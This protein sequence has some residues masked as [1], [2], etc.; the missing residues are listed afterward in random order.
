MA[1]D[2]DAVRAVAAQVAAALQAA[3][4]TVLGG[5]LDPEVRWGPPGDPEPPCQ[6]RDQVL[7]W[8][9]RGRDAGTR[10]TVTETVVSGDRILVGMRVTG[11]PAGNGPHDRWQVLT[12]RGGR[13]AEIAGF[14]DRIHA[15]EWAG[16]AGAGARAGGSAAGGSAEGGSAE[17]AARWVPPREPL[18]DD[19]VVVRLPAPSDADV[20]HA[21]AAQPGGLDGTWL[22][23]GEGAT[24]ASCEWLISD[25]LAGW[26]SAY[27]FHGPAL[28]ITAAGCG[29]LVGQVGLRARGE[30]A[31]EL[32]YGVAPAHRGRGYAARAVRLVAG[33]LL[34]E[35]QA[36]EI[37]LRISQD[38]AVS[39]RVAVAAGFERAGTVMSYVPGTG[40]T[41]EDLRFVLRH[42]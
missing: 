21:Y 2:T 33:W 15:A 13:V 32:D 10:A 30:R 5:L 9:R 11:R 24:T 25:W 38:H 23:L 8:Y 40:E 41:F 22:P 28:V 4:L 17:G 31:A 20:L 36:D 19:V 34:A 14:D 29:D 3:D 26:G 39:Q 12:V 16:L 35:G 37:E 1:S 6:S 42:C 7:S 18:A 27:S